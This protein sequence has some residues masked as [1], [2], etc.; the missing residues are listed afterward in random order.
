MHR[1]RVWDLPTRLFHWSLVVAVVGLIVTGSLGGNWMEWH[2]R[3]G[4]A[5][6]TLLLFRLAWG[7]LGGH[8]SRFGNF[9]YSP[10]TVWRY[11][12]G[13]G[14]PELNVG[15]NPLGALSVFTMLTVLIAQV[16]S[17]L[18]SD[19]EIAFFGPLTRWVNLETVQ[20]STEYHTEIGK[21]LL[22]L[23]VALHLLALLY[24]RLFK[25]E[26]LVRAM[27][28]GDKTLNQPAQA[29]LD[30]WPQRLLACALLGACA[31]IVAWVVSLGQV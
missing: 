20:L 1:V 11:L 12:K 14:A 29:S 21:P 13:R 6:M 24:H 22:I 31:G 30:G 27:V 16:T 25:G 26:R 15:H 18:F 3:L 7:L 23:L 28:S 17:G 9:L 4:Y 10:I 19:D 2:L 8:W 5:A